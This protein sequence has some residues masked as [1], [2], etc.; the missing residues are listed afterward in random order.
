MIILN[1]YMLYNIL[2]LTYVLEDFFA[3][4]LIPN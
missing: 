4:D 2:F 3:F 1:Y